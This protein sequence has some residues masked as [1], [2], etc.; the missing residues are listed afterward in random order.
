MTPCSSAHSQWAWLWR[1]KK[2]KQ[3]V[4]QQ[5]RL[6]EEQQDIILLKWRHTTRNRKGLWPG[7]SQTFWHTSEHHWKWHH[8]NILLIWDLNR[9]RFIYTNS[10]PPFNPTGHVSPAFTNITCRLIWIPFIRQKCLC[11]LTLITSYFW[12]HSN[13]D[14][15][16]P[17]ELNQFHSTLQKSWA[18]QIHCPSTGPGWM[19]QRSHFTRIIAE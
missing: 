18:W 11:N 8:L 6:P 5:T 7:T 19:L 4:Q 14:P 9:L 10:S 1:F 3:P 15:V 2:E 12:P 17:Q 13:I 16:F